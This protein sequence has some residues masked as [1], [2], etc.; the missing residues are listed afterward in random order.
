MSM[1]REFST[2]E[3]KMSWRIRKRLLSEDAD[4]YRTR[5]DN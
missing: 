2:V 1:D 4:Y 5:F 3:N